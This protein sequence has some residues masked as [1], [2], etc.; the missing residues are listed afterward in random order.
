MIN[1]LRHLAVIL[2]GNKRWSK[3]NNKKLSEGYN[4]GLNKIL[5][6]TEWCTEN[7]LKYLT[8]FTLSSENIKRTNINLLFNLISEKNKN[9][10]K[11]INNKNIKIKFIGNIGAIKPKIREL[12]YKI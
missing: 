10:K 11:I 2:D 3:K 12:F 4:S 6:L 5:E 1:K 7:N 9:F 8:I